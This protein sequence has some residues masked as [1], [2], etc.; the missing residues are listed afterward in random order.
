MSTMKPIMLDATQDT[1]KVE[2]DSTKNLFKVTERSL[3]ENAIEFYDPILEWLE[4]YSKNPN[5]ETIFDFKLEY[6]NT[7]SSK[8]IIKIIL[9]LEKVAVNNKVKIRWYYRSIDEDMESLGARYDRL[10]KVEFEL[11]EY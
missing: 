7:A 11:I 9:I 8:Q 5:N 1:P 6:F 4:E 10:I 3:P 2:L